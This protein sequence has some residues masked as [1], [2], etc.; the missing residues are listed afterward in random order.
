MNGDIDGLRKSLL[1]LNQW[2]YKALGVKP[3]PFQQVLYG[4]LTLSAIRSRWTQEYQKKGMNLLAAATQVKRDGKSGRE[5]T[6]EDIRQALI[7][8][9]APEQLCDKIFNDLVALRNTIKLN[10]KCA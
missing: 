2:F 9:Q 7:D 4:N 5:Y 8:C 10:R 6:D 3:R 1:D